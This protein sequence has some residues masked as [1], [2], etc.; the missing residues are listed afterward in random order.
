MS[1]APLIE[2]VFKQHS[3]ANKTGKSV[4][5]AAIGRIVDSVFE[6]VGKQIVGKGYFRYPGFGSFLIKYARH[7]AAARAGS[8]LGIG[9]G[10]EIALLTRLGAGIARRG[11]CSGPSPRLRARRWIGQRRTRSRCPHAA[12]L[13]SSLRLRSRSP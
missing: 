12:S 10:D 7:P 4:S 5:K 2:A 3:L 8:R 1:K 13:A 6:Q 9:G 11:R